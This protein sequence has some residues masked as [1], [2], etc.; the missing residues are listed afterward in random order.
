MQLAILILAAGKASRMG[1]V[2]QL[3][4]VNGTSLLENA[5]SNSK[6]LKKSTVICVLGAHATEIKKT[7]DLKSIAFTI[8]K[9]Y[10][11]GISSSIIAGIKYIQKQE[12]QFD[13]LFVQLADQPAIELAYYREMIAL[14]SKEKTKIIAANYGKKYGVPAIFPKAFINDLLKITGDKGAKEF[15]QKNKKEIVSPEVTVN[16]LD[17]DTREEYNNYINTL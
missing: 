8:N 4:K 11:K 5:I 1:A 9:D 10:T 16:L 12:I 3:L 13:G 6:K 17:I 7:I 14:F 15:L 2:K